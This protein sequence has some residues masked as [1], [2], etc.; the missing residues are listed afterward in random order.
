[1]RPND[2]EVSFGVTHEVLPRVALDVQYTWHSF[3]NFVASQNTTRPPSSYDFFCVT[4]PTAPAANS[5][6][7]LPN[8]GQQ[9]CGFADL[10][11]L[12]STTVP[13]FVVQRASNFGKVSDVYTGVDINFNARLPRGGSASGGTSIGHQVQDI[14]AVAGEASV[15]YAAVAGVTASTAGTLAPT[16]GSTSAGGTPSTLYCRIQPPFQPDVKGLLSYPLPWFGL[17][18]SATLQNRPGPQILAT[19]NVTNALVQNLGRNLN[20]GTATTGLIAPGTLYGDRFTQLDVRFGKNFRFNG[21]RVSATLDVY[22]LM[23]SSAILTQNNTVGPNWRTPTSILQGR[24][25]KFGAQLD[26]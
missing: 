24:L 19:Y 11:P 26:F 15:T 4:A 20:S 17:T 18:A 22:N 7:V 2:Q 5:G 9:I 6:F 23:N 1:M 13:F 16:Y 10:N 25:V 14:C 8:A 21:R 12:F 3:G